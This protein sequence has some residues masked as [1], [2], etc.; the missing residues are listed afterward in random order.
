[1]AIS[2]ASP[3]MCITVDNDDI[4]WHH[5]ASCDWPRR[6]GNH[7]VRPGGNT[8]LKTVPHVENPLHVMGHHQKETNI[9]IGFLRGRLGFLRAVKVETFEEW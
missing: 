7:P 8:D 9:N 2:A 6:P 3:S 1:M 5:P 4:H